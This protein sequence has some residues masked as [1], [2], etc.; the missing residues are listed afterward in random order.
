MVPMEALLDELLDL[1]E[2][3]RAAALQ[4]RSAEDPEVAAA[5]RRWLDAVRASSGFLSSPARPS[6]ESFEPATVV[7]IRP[8]WRECWSSGGLS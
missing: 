6:Q 5:V 7:G 4:K 2:E 1:P 3:R 8:F